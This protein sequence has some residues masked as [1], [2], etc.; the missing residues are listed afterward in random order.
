MGKNNRKREI[1]KGWITRYCAY[2]YTQ[3][4]PAQNTRRPW[5]LKGRISKE[6]VVVIFTV[7]A[8]LHRHLEVKR[9]LRES[10]KDAL[11]VFVM[12][13]TNRASEVK[14]I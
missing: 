13:F 9:H 8:L 12:L 7:A 1:Q 3:H 14:S 10:L 2:A 11:S 6:A 4:I 5:A